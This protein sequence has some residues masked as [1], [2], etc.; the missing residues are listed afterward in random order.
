MIT[1]KRPRLAAGAV[2][3]LLTLLA[4]QP[5]AENPLWVSCIVNCP[6]LQVWMGPYLVVDSHVF[7]LNLLLHSGP[8]GGSN[9]QGGHSNHGNTLIGSGCQWSNDRKLTK[10]ALGVFCDSWVTVL[11]ACSQHSKRFTYRCIYVA[12]RCKAHPPKASY[13]RVAG[14]KWWL[15]VLLTATWVCLSHRGFAFQTALRLRSSFR[16]YCVL[17]LY[18][19][20]NVFHLLLPFPPNCFLFDR[21]Q[22]ML[23]P[24]AAVSF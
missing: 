24:A 12:A 15:N 20:C 18:L 5:I 10:Y 13:M 3:L 4:L 21:R 16:T 9:C 6:S 8:L 23:Y 7:F 11:G 1:H 22:E 17:L 19:G 14:A 2:G